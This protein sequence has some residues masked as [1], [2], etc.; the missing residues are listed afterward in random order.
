MVQDM[1]IQYHIY[2]KEKFMNKLKMNKIEETKK[3]EKKT[4]LKKA[5]I[6]NICFLSTL[7]IFM[8]F[9]FFMFNFNYAYALSLEEQKKIV[10]ENINE[11]EERKKN[12]NTNLNTAGKEF[13]EIQ[14]K[15]ISQR[16]EIEKLE[17]DE[18]KLYNE[19]VELEKD[20][21]LTESRANN[22]SDVVK[23]RLIAIYEA[24]NYS[25]WE[26]LLSSGNIAEFISNYR[27]LKEIAKNDLKMFSEANKEFEDQKE[28]KEKFNKIYDKLMQM[29]KELEQKRV[30]QENLVILKNKKIEN[31]TDEQK[32]L[33]AK[34]EKLEESRKQID[35]EIQNES[36]EF[37]RIERYVG[38][39]FEWPVPSCPS[40]KWITATYGMGYKSGYPG[41]FHTG[42]DIAPPHAIVG[43]AKAVAVADGRVITA[44]RSNVGYGN[45]VV[46]DHGGGVFTLY[47]HASK[48]LVSAGDM[49]KKGQDILVIGSTGNSTGP[50]LH[51]EL[52]IGGS[53][54]KYHTDGLPYITS[55]K[56]PLEDVTND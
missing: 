9:N 55:P 18:Y 46:I 37:G 11:A 19:G 49:V 20:L 26:I 51:F 16:K 1:L 10:E 31:L 22:I 27:M 43:Q 7:I 32:K 12:I 53:E 40:T 5:Y 52:R 2:I 47:G 29:K 30:V 8:F 41:F 44:G 56:I 28:K 4:F 39:T 35:K 36:V 17:E 33:F 21:K 13:L 14:N 25:K 34:L 38:G 45:Y 42:V 54:Y 3:K 23:E 50:H 6:K 48:L 24:G 15:L